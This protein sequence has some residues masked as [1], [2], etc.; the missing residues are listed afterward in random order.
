VYAGGPCPRWS[1]SAL[2]PDRGVLNDD[3]ILAHR[4]ANPVSV[5][6]ATTQPA[7][8]PSSSARR[9][10]RQ[11]RLRN[12]EAPARWPWRQAARGTW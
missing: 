9:V 6:R 7:A 12:R 5:G 11:G 10:R 8:A 1:A 4:A 2:R 3:Y